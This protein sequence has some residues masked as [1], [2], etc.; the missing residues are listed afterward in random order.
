MFSMMHI[1]SNKISQAILKNKFVGLSL[2]YCRQFLCLQGPL[3]RFEDYVRIIELIKKSDSV[4]YLSLQVN[5]KVKS[6]LML[7]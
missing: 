7:L 4:L 2:N 6:K 3:Y 1:G 5:E